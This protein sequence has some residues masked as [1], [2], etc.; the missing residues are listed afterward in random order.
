M[1]LKRR[2]LAHSPTAAAATTLL[3]ANANAITWRLSGRCRRCA[4]WQPTSRALANTRRQRLA[5]Q[6]AC[7]AA[8]HRQRQRLAFN[9]SLAAGGGSA[10]RAESHAVRERLAVRAAHTQDSQLQPTADS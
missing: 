5:F 10:A 9:R 6:P 2:E 8:C 3:I 4:S 1:D 7:P